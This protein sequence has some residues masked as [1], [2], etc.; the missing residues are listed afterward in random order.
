M[1]THKHARLT[2]AR[3]LEMVNQM[4]DSGMSLG[5][6]GRGDDGGAHDGAGAHEQPLLGQVGVDLFEQRLGQVVAVRSRMHGA[7]LFR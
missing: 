6:Y 5:R 7:C 4:T 3:R 2:Y 1:N